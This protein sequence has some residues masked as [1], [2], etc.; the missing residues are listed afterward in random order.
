MCIEVEGL[1]QLSL[2]P[3]VIAE[4]IYIIPGEIR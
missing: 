3:V 1:Q 2:Y 4:E